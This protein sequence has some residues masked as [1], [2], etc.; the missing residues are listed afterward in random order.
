MQCQHAG[1]RG[2]GWR[3]THLFDLQIDWINDIADSAAH[4]AKVRIVTQASSIFQFPTGSPATTRR[5]RRG[6]GW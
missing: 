1:G 6:A 2:G 4:L 3:M 5:A